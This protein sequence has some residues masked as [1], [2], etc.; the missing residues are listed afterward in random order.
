MTLKRIAV[1]FHS[2]IHLNF[3]YKHKV[4][5]DDIPKY[6]EEKACHKESIN[7]SFPFVNG[8]AQKIIFI[9]MHIID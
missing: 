9:C 7:I 8:Y 5:R 4:V 3:S 6:K 1:E 2:I